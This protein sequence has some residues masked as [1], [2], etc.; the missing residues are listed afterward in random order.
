MSIRSSNRCRGC[1][2]RPVNPTIL[3]RA[4]VRK[5][6]KEGKAFVKRVFAQPKIWIVGDEHDLARL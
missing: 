6:V 1:L 2:G 4:A 3:T 5:G